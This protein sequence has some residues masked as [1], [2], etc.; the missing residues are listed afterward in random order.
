MS[1]LVN[2][3][4]EHY[5][6]DTSK[7]NVLKCLSKYTENEM[8]VGNYIFGRTTDCQQL[9]R[10]S[11]QAHQ[12]AR[13]R[14]RK[15]ALLQRKLQSMR[16]KIHQKT[17][18]CPKLMKATKQIPPQIQ[19]TRAFLS[20]NNHVPRKAFPRFSKQPAHADPQITRNSL[21][22]MTGTMTNNFIIPQY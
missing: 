14:I 18:L 8:N 5:D 11:F 12:P 17:I 19:K 3:A 1:H 4:Y 9:Q 7:D 13:L 22:D 15:Q 2:T 10:S 20:H 6:K 16:T 21:F